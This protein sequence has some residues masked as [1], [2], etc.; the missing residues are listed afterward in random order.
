MESILKLNKYLVQIIHDYNYINIDK[1]IEKSPKI[2]TRCEFLLKE[3]YTINDIIIKSIQNGYKGFY[4]SQHEPFS[5]YFEK[6]I[7]E[8]ILKTIYSN[9]NCYS[10]KQD[11][12]VMRNGKFI[13][14]FELNVFDIINS[15]VN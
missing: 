6:Q 13:S 4:I 8:N 11:K 10:F 9:H 14:L 2:K 15:L 5:D 12:R 1:I 3:Y 7:S